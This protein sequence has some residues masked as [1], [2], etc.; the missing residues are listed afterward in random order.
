MLKLIRIIH[1]FGHLDIIWVLVD[2]KEGQTNSE[3]YAI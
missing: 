2:I 1:F 3:N